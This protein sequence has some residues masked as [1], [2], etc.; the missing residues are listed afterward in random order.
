MRNSIK[1]AIVDD[2]NIYRSV[3]IAYL[4]TFKDIEIIIEA[5][6]GQ[7]LIDAMQKNKEPDI[8]LLDLEMPI[9]CGIKTT[10]YLFKEYPNAKILILSMHNNDELFNYLIGKG[11]NSFIQKDIGFSLIIEAIY[12]VQKTKYYFANVD[13]KKIIAARKTNNIKSISIDKV[14]FSKREI[15]V[16]ELICQQ[17]TNKE[18]SEK[19]F[20]SP[21]TVDGHRNN[22]L[23]K[24]NAH[25]TVG[26]VIFAL[27][28]GLV[29]ANLFS[30]ESL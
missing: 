15:E 13:L 20:I 1:L 6:N 9:M 10:E 7:E 12:A 11:V 24:A 16:A 17:Y 18:I 8:I 14:V 29:S 19:L 23:Q 5:S 4:K 3:L 25:N 27:K 26:L 28:K 2:D 22:L 30:I 21:R